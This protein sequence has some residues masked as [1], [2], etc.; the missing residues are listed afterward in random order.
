MNKDGV[1]LAATAMVCSSGVNKFLKINLMNL[2]LEII[3]SAGVDSYA[4]NPI[5]WTVN[6]FEVE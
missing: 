5:I 6:S 4:I 3:S 1:T 2:S